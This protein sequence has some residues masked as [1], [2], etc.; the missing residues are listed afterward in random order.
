[1]TEPQRDAIDERIRDLYL[2][3][4]SDTEIAKAIGLHRVTVTRRRLAM[5]IT[6]SDR[7]PAA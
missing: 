2:R 5:G 3:R 4:Y 6:K 7:K 1:M